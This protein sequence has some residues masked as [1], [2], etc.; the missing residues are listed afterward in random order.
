MGRENRSTLSAKLEHGI[1][2]DDQPLL[3]GGLEMVA[4]RCL[5]RPARG[6]QNVAGR[7][8]TRETRAEA[9]QSGGIIVAETLH[10]R[11]A[12]DGETAQPVQDGLG[13]SGPPGEVGIDVEGIL[14]AAEPVESGLAGAGGESLPEGGRSQ[15]RHVSRHNPRA[16]FAAE[17]ARAAIQEEGLVLIEPLTFSRLRHTACLNEGTR[18]AL[19]E[20][21]LPHKIGEN[22]AFQRHGPVERD[23]MFTV[24]QMLQIEPRIGDKIGHVVGHE[25]HHGEGGKRCEFLLVDV[26]QV[27]RVAPAADAQGILDQR[28]PIIAEGDLADGRTDAV[29]SKGHGGLPL[30]C[31]RMGDEMPS[32]IRRIKIKIK[33]A[34]QGCRYSDRRGDQPSGG[35]AEKDGAGRDWCLFCICQSPRIE[36][37]NGGGQPVMRAATNRLGWGGSHVLS[38][39]GKQGGIMLKRILDALGA[40]LEDTPVLNRLI[41]QMKQW[42]DTQQAARAHLVSVLT[43]VVASFERAHAIVL[44]E[45][46]ILSGATTPQEYK[47]ISIEKIDRG[48]FYD[49][50]KTNDICSHVHQLHAD[51]RSGFGDIADSIVLGAAKRLGRALGEFEQGEYTLAEQYQEHLTRV[52][53]SPATVNSMEDLTDALTEIADEQARL[54]TELAE[55]TRFKRRLLQISL[56]D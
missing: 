13:E 56:Y 41:D 32:T 11:P 10:R 27:G 12:G 50:F 48:K 1:G 49:L 16:P 26:S 52:L 54:S 22:G 6:D 46:S 8:G 30:Q 43:N 51:L 36:R 35:P 55:L 18:I 3:I 45:L 37:S 33:G 31:R 38:C 14:V 21:R 47:D 15:G 20:N 42:G 19:V 2:K 5:A 25:G 28:V 23:V 34:H 29:A 4:A 40:L 7:D 24:Q 39:R 44:I 9:G 17:I 53:M